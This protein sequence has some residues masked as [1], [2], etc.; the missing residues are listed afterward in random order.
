MPT[1]VSFVVCDTMHIIPTTLKIWS[2]VNAKALGQD[3]PE[4]KKKKN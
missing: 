2:P 3:K 1:A 4:N